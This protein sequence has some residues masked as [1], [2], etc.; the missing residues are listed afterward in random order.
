MSAKRFSGEGPLI[1]KIKRNI[2]R[3]RSAEYAR[4]LDEEIKKGKSSKVAEKIAANRAD[5]LFSTT[6][7]NQRVENKDRNRSFGKD[8]IAIRAAPL[9]K[10]R[11]NMDMRIRM[12]KANIIHI[13]K[14]IAAAR[15]KKEDA[16]A[17]PE[18]MIDIDD[19]E[20]RIIS[21]TEE[22]QRLQRL[23]EELDNQLESVSRFSLGGRTRSKNSKPKKYRKSNKKTQRRRRRRRL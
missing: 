7:P 6:P 4:V 10:E 18:D 15:V 21:N 17:N 13:T 2:E 9:L 1:R 8:A 22:I 5:E 3:E 11:R 23:L 20:L 12:L 14:A 19:A 16:N